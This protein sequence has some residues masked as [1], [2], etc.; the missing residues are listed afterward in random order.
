MST[1]DDRD[2]ILSVP[3]VENFRLSISGYFLLKAPEDTVL[4]RRQRIVAK[5]PH[6]DYIFTVK[7]YWQRPTLYCKRLTVEAIRPD[8]GK[9]LGFTLEENAVKITRWSVR[10]RD[11]AIT[12]FLELARFFPIMPWTC[13]AKSSDFCCVCGRPMTDPLSRARGI[14]PECLTRVSGYFG[15]QPSS[16]S[17]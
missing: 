3:A 4:K 14:G 7:P 11:D 15:P 12:N 1:S 16:S 2:D 8:I 5:L 9:A 13:F 10:H 17:H 6:G